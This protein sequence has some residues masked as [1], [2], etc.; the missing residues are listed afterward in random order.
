MA[1]DNLAARRLYH[2]AG[3][4]AVGRRRGYYRQGGEARTA[5]VMALALGGASA[6]GGAP[7]GPGGRPAAKENP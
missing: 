2:G 4:V 3:L 5:L 1:E 7:S 6:A